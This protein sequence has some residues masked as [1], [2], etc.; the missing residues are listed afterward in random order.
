M[1][2]PIKRKTTRKDIAIEAGVSIS[3]VSR[4]LNDSGYVSGEKKERVLKAVEKL[5]YY[6]D[7]VAFSLSRKATRQLLFYS[8]ELENAFNIELYEGMISE[9]GKNGYMI[10][11]NGLIELNKVQDVMMDGIILPNES[12]AERYMQTVGKNLHIP[13][14]AASYGGEFH[15]ER[16]MPIVECDLWKGIEKVITYLRKRGHRKIAMMSVYPQNGLNQANSRIL[17]WRE[18]MREYIGE[19]YKKYYF[20]ICREDLLNDERALSFEKDMDRGD[21]TIP[22]DFFGK[23]R[24]GA[25]IFVEKRSDATA[26]ICFNDELALGL[27]RGLKEKGVRVPEDVSIM[28]IDGTYASRYAERKLTSLCLNPVKQGSECV[29]VLMSMINREKYK[30]ITR[31][32][33]NIREGDTIKE[34]GSKP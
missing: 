25:E 12:V 4:V 15:F 6:R 1:T 32:P 7:P 19:E 18:C 16:S 5:G 30:H 22:E 28:G 21:F 26:I 2:E 31:I 20:G 3:V 8:G 9:A 10:L 17:A 14:V 34:L 11:M 27:C 33:L 13:A 29:K 23:G 24:L